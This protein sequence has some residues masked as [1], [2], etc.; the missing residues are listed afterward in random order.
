[1]K[2]FDVNLVINS[3]KH[4]VDIISHLD[5]RMQNKVTKKQLEA[6][7]VELAYMIE[8]AFRDKF[9]IDSIKVNV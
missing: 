2:R 5:V 9:E 4:N 8:K 6:F 7:N 3:E 1:M